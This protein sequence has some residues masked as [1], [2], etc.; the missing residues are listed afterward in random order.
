MGRGVIPPSGAVETVYLHLELES[1]WDW[2]DFR[3]NVRCVLEDRYPSLSNKYGD[4]WLDREC[5]VIL[6]NDHARVTVSEYCGCIAICLVPYTH[7]DQEYPE[8]AESWCNQIS[9][10]FRTCLHETFRESAMQYIAT[11]SNGIPFYRGIVQ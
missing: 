11:G 2:E 8:L 1:T 3:D 4:E 10:G 7:S 5:E 9:L 6:K